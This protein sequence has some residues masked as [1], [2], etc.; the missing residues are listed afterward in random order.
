MLVWA[1]AHAVPNVGV[2]Q[3]PQQ[4]ATP[5]VAGGT[6]A[7]ASGTPAFCPPPSARTTTRVLRRSPAAS[8]YS[9]DQAVRH[10]ATN[11]VGVT[12]SG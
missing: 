7:T 8:T 3:E 11:Y 5:E 2:E 1:L 12:A 6:S 9:A 4:D 10:R